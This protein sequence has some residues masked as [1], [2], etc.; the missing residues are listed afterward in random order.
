MDSQDYINEV[1]NDAWIDR[2]RDVAETIRQ[3]RK[4]LSN[5][6]VTDY[7]KGRSRG[8]HDILQLLEKE[9]GDV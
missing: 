5:C 6:E 9:F 4:K 8:Y 3:T 2:I 1:L 7:N